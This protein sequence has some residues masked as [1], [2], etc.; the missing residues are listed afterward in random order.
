MNDTQ[1][2]LLGAIILTGGASRRMGQ[3]KAALLWGERRAVDLVVDLARSVGAGRVLTAGEMD[4]GFERVRDPAP[5]SGPVAGVLAGLAA[6]GGS[7]RRVLVLA[8]DAPTLQPADLAPLLA[9]TGPGATFA[10]FPLPMVLDPAA[11]PA[12]VGLGW[13]VRRLAE[14][15]GLSQLPLPPGAA[16]RI[17]GANTEAER[18]RLLRDAGMASTPKNRAS[19]AQ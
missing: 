5:Q 4:Y 2:A 9:A 6:L 3:D 10:D 13:P 17:R 16:D 11:T 12:D 18:L 8:V 15:A 1:I 14:A 7:F 19:G